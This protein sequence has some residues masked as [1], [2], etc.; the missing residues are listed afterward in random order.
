MYSKRPGGC[1]IG[2][3]GHLIDSAM[4]LSLGEPVAI[5]LSG[6]EIYAP[7]LLAKED[8]AE[9]RGAGRRIGGEVNSGRIVFLRRPG[10]SSS[11]PVL[12][13]VSR[14]LSVSIAGQSGYCLL[15][16]TIFRPCDAEGDEQHAWRPRVTTDKSYRCGDRRWIAL[17]G[18]VAGLWGSAADLCGCM[19]DACS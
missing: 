14:V 8:V 17:S 19:G 11:P 2:G 9:T 4:V 15:C 13:E 12:R 6:R 18:G 7:G 10:R 3:D 16:S 1:V 5:E